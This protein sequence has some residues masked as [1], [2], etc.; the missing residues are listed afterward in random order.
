MAAGGNNQNLSIT[1]GANMD[2]SGVLGAVKQMQGAFN[3]LKLPSNMTGDVLKNF[4]KLTESLSKFEKL[5]SQDHFSKA[6]I[7][8]LQKLQKEIDSTFGEL[9]GSLTDLSGQKFYLEADYTKIKE[10]RQAVD[11]LKTDIQNKLNS[12][13]IDFSSAK[14]GAASLGLDTL[15]NRMEQGVKTS[16]TLTSAMSEIG[17]SIRTGNLSAASEQFTQM[18]SKAKGLKGAS[19][20][21]LDTFKQWGLV[22][23]SG[24]ASNIKSMEER[25]RLLNQVFDKLVPIFSKDG[26]AIGQLSKELTTATDKVKD[27]E[28]IGTENYNNSIANS[29]SKTEE[30]GAAAKQTGQS[31]TE[32]AEGMRRASDEVKQLQ[33]STQYFF[34]LRNMINLLKRGIREAVDVVKE[35]DAAMTETAVVTD[36]SVGDMWQKLPEY[37][38]NAN[39]LGAS[40]KDM[41]EA[42]TLYY[43]QGLRTEAA[44]GI[45]NETM[46]MARIG[47]LEAADAT[48]KMTAA[49]RGFNMEI[50]EASAQRVNDVYS[51]LAAKTASDTEEL[52][53]AMQRTASIAASAGM[54]FEGT[55]AFLAQAIETTREPA[56]NLGTAMKTIVARFTELKKN[57]LEIAEVDGEEVSYNKVD[58]ALQSIGVSLK[59][60]NGQFRD[61][62][63]VFLDIS[64][65]WDSLTQTQQRYVATTAAGSRQ[66]SRFIAMMSNYER[67]MQLMDYANN[68]AGASNEQFGKTMESLEAKLNKLKNAWNEFLMNIMNDS[69]TK[70]IVD[71]GTKILNVVN[72]IIEALSFGGKA[73]GIKSA[74]SLFTAFTALKATGR[75]ANRAIGGLGGLIDPQSSFKEGFKGG[76]LGGKNTAQAKAISQPIV[77]S[78]SKISGQIAAIA[79][80]QGI[81]EA[82]QKGNTAGVKET[83]KEDYINTK[84]L[85][86]QLSNKEGFKISEASNL[87]GKLD[88]THQLSMFNNNPGT[89]QAM[90]Q[91]SLNWFGGLG[92]SK[93]LEKEG[94]GYISSIY[95]GMQQ[96]QIPVE[97][98]IE[99][100]G[101]PQKWGQYFGTETAQAYSKSFIKESIPA[102]EESTQIAHE[103]A[104]YSLGLNPNDYKVGSNEIKQ[105]FKDKNNKQLKEDYTALYSGF[106]KDIEKSTGHG[107]AKGTV[108][109]MGRL[110]ND[111]GA[112]ADRF[113]QAGYGISA[114]GSLLAQLGGPIGAVGVGIQNL[115]GIVS[116]VGMSISA[117]TGLFSLFTEGIVTA[118]GAVLVAGSTIATVV[119][120]IAALGAALLIAH[121]H[122]KKIKEAGEEVTNTFNETSK[123]VEGNIAKLKSYQGE[124]AILSK[125]V[126]NNGNNISLDDSQYQRYLEIVDDIA[127]INPDIVEGYNAQGHAIINNN[128]ALAETLKLQEQIKDKTYETYTNEASLQKL[129][130]ARNINKDYKNIQTQEYGVSMG[131]GHGNEGRNATGGIG[132]AVPLAGDVSSIADKL[133]LL[134]GTDGLGNTIKVNDSML[135]KYGIESLDALISGEEQAVKKFIKHRDQIQADLAN[136][137][138]ELNEG[139]L[140]GFEKLGEDADAFDAAIQPVY[141][142]LLA[143]VSNSKVFESIAPEFREA[144]NMGLKDLASQDLS[145]G[146]MAKAANNMA[147]RFANL[148]TGSGK[149]KEA[150]D[151]V[152]EAQTNFANT[153]NETQYHADVQPAI[154]DLTRLKEA[155]LNEGTAYGNA[156]AEYLDNQIQKISH[157]TEEGTVSLTEA[158]NGA[159]DDLAAAE[160]AVD[161]FN[162][163]T[164]KD[165]YTAAE[166][167]KSVYDKAT[168]TFK[169]TLGSEIEKH[170]E[171]SGDKTAW[172][173][174]RTLF[175]E[176]ALKGL[177]ASELRKKF[178]EWEPALREGEEGWYHFWDKITS[179]SKLMESLNAIDGVHWDEDDFYIPEDK[180]SEVAKTIGISEEMLT[181]MLN[182]G[183]QFADIDF[184]NWDQ[185]REALATDGSAIKGASSKGG[186]N[187]LY[188]KES[189]FEAALSDAGFT[190]EQYDAQKKKAKEQNIDLLKPAEEYKKGS[191]EL[192]KK[193][194]DMGVKT[195]PDL[196]K[197]LNDTGQFTK[198]EIKGYADKLGMTR[199]DEIFASTYDDI[200]SA[201][202]NPEIAKQT[203]I[204]QDINN[205]LAA[206][207]DKRD[208]KQHTDANEDFKKMLYGKEG[209][210]DT[211][212]QKFSLGQNEKGEKL[213]AG[214]YAET[215]KNML[216]MSASAKEQAEH[217]KVLAANAESASDSKF[218]TNLANSYEKGANWI[219]KWVAQG[220]KAYTEN[221]ALRQKEAAA[222]AARYDGRQQEQEVTQKAVAN[223][224]KTELDERKGREAAKQEQRKAAKKQEAE[225]R[226]KEIEARNAAKAEQEAAKKQEAERNAKD[227]LGREQAKQAI[228]AEQ[229]AG[230]ESQAQFLLQKS[231][232]ASL[233]NAINGLDAN[234]IAQD[235]AQSQAFSNLYADLIN[236]RLPSPQDL[237]TLGIFT[238]L[239]SQLQ[240]KITNDYQS[241]FDKV[242]ETDLNISADT[243]QSFLAV[244]EFFKSAYDVISQTDKAAAAIDIAGNDVISKSITTLG[245]R[246]KSWWDQINGIKPNTTQSSSTPSPQK[247]IEREQTKG[248]TRTEQLKTIFSSEGADKVKQEEDEVK[249]KADKGAEHTT[250]FKAEDTGVESKLKKL[251][252]NKTSTVTVKATADTGGIDNAAKQSVAKP[253]TIDDKATPKIKQID[254]AARKQITKKINVS[255]NYTGTWHKDFII[256]VK[257]RGDNGGAYTGL[258]NKISFYHVPQAGSLAAGTKKGKV[259]PKNQGGLTLTGEQGYEIAWI[260]S[261]SK[262]AILGANGPQM[263]DLPKDAVVYNHDQS[264]EILKRKGILGGSLSTGA[265]GSYSGSSRYGGGS[266]GGGGVSTYT[267]KRSGGKK[268]G[269]SKAKK[270]TN[271]NNWSIEEVVR[272]DINQNLE[273]LTSDL[274]HITDDI[275]K[276]LTKIGKTSNQI[277]SSVQ[278]QIQN[279]KD[280][281]KYNQDLANSYQRQFDAMLKATTATYKISYTQSNGKS[282][283]KM[284]NPADYIFKNEFGTYEVDKDAISKLQAGKKPN[285]NSDRALQESVFNEVNKILSEYQSG[286][287]KA[288]DEIDNLQKQIEENAKKIAEAYY[289]WEN[290]LTEVYDLSQQIAAQ[291]AMQ[292]RFSSQVA[293]EFARLSTGFG[294][295]AKSIAVVTK[296]NQRNN[297]TLLQQI[298][299]QKT[300]IEARERELD[301][302]TTGV[303]ELEKLTVLRNKGVG[304]GEGEFATQE[305]KDQAVAAMEQ[306]LK[307]VETA[308][309]YFV[310]G[311]PTKNEDGSLTYSIDWDK[312]N[313]DTLNGQLSEETA[314]SVKDYFEK[315]NTANVD[316]NNAIKE[317]TDTIKATYDK[318]KEYQDYIVDFEDTLLQ[319]LD[320]QLQKE[321]DSAEKLGSTITTSLKD[322]LD[323]VK[324]KLDE[325]RK[326]EDNAKT[327]RDISQKQQRLA[328][329]R[330]D[331]SGGHQVE[332]A[333]LQ[334]E[335]AE[336]QQSYGRTLEDQLL[337]RL[338]QQGDEAAKQRERQ[339]ELAQAQ[340]DISNSNNKELVNMWLQD[341]I[342]YR[343]EIKEAWMQA[344]DYKSKGYLA[345]KQLNDTFNSSFAELVQATEETKASQEGTIATITDVITG[346]G[347]T[348]NTQPESQ[349]SFQEQVTNA[350]AS[351]STALNAQANPL[352]DVAFHNT[353]NGTNKLGT[354][355]KATV[356]KWKSQGVNKE[357]ARAAGAPNSIVEEVYKTPPTPPASPAPPAAPAPPSKPT[358]TKPTN[359]Y[360]KTSEL[361]KTITKKSSKNDIKSLQWSL[362]QLGY[363]T[364]AIDGKW[365]KAT[366]KAVAAFEKKLYGHV[367]DKKVGPQ[368]KAGFKARGYKTGG[369]ADYTGPAWLDGTPSKP[370]LVL[371]AADTQNFLALRDVLSKAIGSTNSVTNSY[372]GN[373][374][375]EININV[376]KLTNDYDVDR[377]AERVKKIIV[378][379][380]GYRNV[381]QVR[382][383]R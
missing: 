148:T 93:A 358:P 305:V 250:K 235:P 251:G 85:F 90:K 158:L 262:S 163:S 130:N 192:A 19:A 216:E 379:D 196:I 24:P 230:I 59:D 341:P 214:E 221:E 378:K 145:A 116:S 195:L 259:G 253:V 346:F 117:A 326:Q 36:F 61:L 272:F 103:A 337:D 359:P 35:L 194:N 44:M 261:E 78:L 176:D 89:K 46:K 182:K 233:K 18:I 362:Q 159:V 189:A 73:K 107:G 92:L 126:D 157:F 319:Q 165:Y 177:D 308:R 37:T 67:T 371:N 376:D 306:R 38:A 132:K 314:K 141:D 164:K 247:T 285:A 336:A 204:Q 155:A 198:D 348:I 213:S 123:S 43:Q 248:Q 260:P 64:Q 193:F 55:A 356:E 333:Q 354:I 313:K 96:G 206:L 322:L 275:E 199:S 98:G 370:E 209:V 1:I 224:P 351:I 17:N 311:T 4:S 25:G 169:D 137:G 45:A 72:N 290:E 232:D 161:N 108:S 39:A 11:E 252:E 266:S 94:K 65:R 70:G 33:Q 238:Q 170:F 150:L 208:H 292:D 29:I 268:G 15:L 77:S 162:E 128:T 95:K 136:S 226:Q 82:G 86:S 324:R 42:T 63:Q 229:T 239:S 151:I 124:F 355:D 360:G 12:I 254:A 295:T 383:F 249:D 340:L 286:H 303:D 217:Y 287:L 147:L 8:S 174:G 361:K 28:K 264:K 16:K 357:E 234:Q 79:K 293:L 255:P 343:D 223:R 113:T 50:N 81:K 154:D 185:V 144:L 329:L 57:P 202:E 111:V 267:S 99:L 80:R 171:G 273:R 225:G 84:K 317:N 332:I 51:N 203:A 187:T 335:I 54:S 167:M 219:D 106:R 345:Q 139:I 122:F 320:E 338:Q 7:K 310:G 14:G 236:N 265:S 183:R 331:T 334:K 269:T 120:P 220:E 291:T 205:K 304:A 190:P 153:L 191:K 276:D 110:A 23:F 188:V 135:Q 227:R 138:I 307:A 349:I 21:L 58:T 323:E 166:G 312:F 283:D 172:E 367:G 352:Q 284:I 228:Q 30:L 134:T 13:K 241:A 68:S 40:V 222:S 74:L 47:G 237:D 3:G 121:Q 201:M 140:K 186:K 377:V 245:E 156:L 257:K 280:S 274:K 316:Y 211:A 34:S 53:T 146:E 127:T 152:E 375:Y 88:E 288:L 365:G 56:E 347:D 210:M 27:L 9:K 369:L 22:D 289:L 381:T 200:I 60:A 97:K 5:A 350:L 6:D 231:I 364:G 215:R 243:N 258:N 297:Q 184:A 115:G 374:T 75:I 298:Q 212:F 242:G 342:K 325:R 168:E 327:E 296:A 300:M 119:G 125:G 382:N 112:V 318:L 380:S 143:N 301:A 302:F 277:A 76:A 366:D 330:A 263:V 100:I 372:G 281:V 2:P 240:D 32:M 270:K 181:A 344:Q 256:N 315:L 244:G 339:I 66:Q 20:E 149:Y 109:D 41:Y 294:D 118:E 173:A 105:L 129:I 101:K 62:D 299:T 175:G 131:Y 353:Q 69:W 142:N 179:D 83:S 328:A 48:D 246:L 197:T 26:E 49:L 114:F 373:A 271:Y 309:K 178:K 52:G 368:D 180:W 218:F 102:M 71:G 104:M 160:A 10:A 207:T 31:T 363:Y 321:I 133:R 87:F 279:L 91:A 282:A 278:D